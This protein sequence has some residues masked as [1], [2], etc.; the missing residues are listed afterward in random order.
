MPTWWLIPVGRVIVAV[1][2][3]GSIFHV[4]RHERKQAKLQPRQPPPPRG[5]EPRRRR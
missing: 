4:S 2:W 3:L 1:A 5:P